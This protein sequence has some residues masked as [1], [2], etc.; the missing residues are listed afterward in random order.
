MA[1][2][3]TVTKR[4]KD[5]EDRY[6]KSICFQSE[7][8]RQRAPGLRAASAKGLLVKDIEGRQYLDFSQSIAILGH[9]HPDI[10][11]AVAKSIPDYLVGGVP[12]WSMMDP[13][14]ELAEETKSNLTGSLRAGKVAY[15]S[16][17][18]ESCDYALGLARSFSKKELV[19]SF[20][21]A[22]H[23]FTGATL[24]VS[25]ITPHLAAHRSSSRAGNVVAPFPGDP[26]F[27]DDEARYE[28]YCV[29]KFRE[30]FQT[31]T[32][33]DEVA[34]MIF[35]PIEVNAGVRIPSQ[36]FWKEIFKTC[37]EHGILTIADEV[38]TGLGRTGRFLGVDHFGVEPDIVCLGKGVGGTLPLGMIVGRSE[39]LDGHIKPN[40]NSASAGNPVCCFAG[41]ESLKVTKR[42]RLVKNSAQLGDYFLRR[43]SMTT[44]RHAVVAG[45]RGLGLILG[46]EI[47]PRNDKTLAAKN[48]ERVMGEAFKRGLLMSRVGIHDNVL[49]IS[50]PMIVTKGQIDTFV[51]RMDESLAAM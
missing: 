50:P 18:A 28:R 21:G 34:G 33:W 6:L 45:V 13:R 7:W 36:S 37:H 40:C 1:T 43:L 32:T 23:G 29:D 51:E 20:A 42:D 3:Q 4:R 25:S 11:R 27:A 9:S 44:E 31:V 15:C 30:L 17:G 5:I 22:Y 38:F 26:D 16:S 19:V 49:R 2:L 12:G 14:V 24:A 10:A 46:I 8:E 35:E 48:A 41:L 47:G 39:I